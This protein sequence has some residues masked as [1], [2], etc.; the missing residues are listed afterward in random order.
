MSLRIVFL[1]TSASVPTVRRSLPSTAILRRAELFLLD[2]GE[3]TQRQLMRVGL[4]LG[5]KTTILVSHLHG[6]HILG[7]PGLLQTMSMM[8]RERP[9]ILHGPPGLEEFL[10][11]FF[12]SVGFQPDYAL[13][14]R[15]STGGLV[16]EERDY[17]VEAASVA[18][19]CFALGYAL[20]ER[21]RPGKF[22]PTR[23]K[24]LGVPEGPLWKRLQS[25]DRVR[26]ADGREVTPR[27]V[28]GPSRSGLKVVYTGDTSPCEAVARLARGADLLVHDGT[29][30]SDM[31][32]RAAAEGHS[33]AAQAGAVA[34]EA[35]ARRLALTHISARYEDH[36]SLANEAQAV[37]GNAFVA[38]DL[39]ELVLR[40]QD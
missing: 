18:H 16:C 6:D 28:L 37:F 26:A 27:E 40:Y 9:L 32:D 30:G 31:E 29:F 2:C 35:K 10:D 22:S 34:I 15:E 4:G 13:E 8:G 19:T 39:M 14:V 5:R 20:T 38:E 3:G 33:T 25:G 12:R 11:C 24:L 17:I 7:L 36:E 23:A 21:P 1:G